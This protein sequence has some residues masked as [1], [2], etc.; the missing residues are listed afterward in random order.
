MPSAIAMNRNDTVAWNAVTLPGGRLRDA[1]GSASGD[2]RLASERANRP[3]AHGKRRSR[4]DPF[5]GRFLHPPPPH[6]GVVPLA[7]MTNP[8]E[9]A[10]PP[11]ALP[12]DAILVP[13]EGMTL[14]QLDEV[15]VQMAAAFLP[16]INEWRVKNGLPPLTD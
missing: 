9:P 6:S 10:R 16:K 8:R 15:A 3:R 11:S 5:D 14:E 7:V 4:W 2:G 12:E 13:T 1:A